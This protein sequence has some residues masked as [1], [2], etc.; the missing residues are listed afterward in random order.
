MIEKYITNLYFIVNDFDRNIS[1]I[2]V[3]KLNFF[4]NISLLIN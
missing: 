2:E 3:N 4:N 1:I